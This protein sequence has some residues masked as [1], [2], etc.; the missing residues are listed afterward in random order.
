MPAR[1]SERERERS[2]D[3]DAGRKSTNSLLFALGFT[4]CAFAFGALGSPYKS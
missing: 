3:A 4:L 1:E 2:I